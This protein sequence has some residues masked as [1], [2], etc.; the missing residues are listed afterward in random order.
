MDPKKSLKTNMSRDPDA[1]FN[2]R[3]ICRP[4]LKTAMP[5]IMN[6]MLAGER[7]NQNYRQGGDYS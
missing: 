1:F 5:H 2:L 4:L 7:M 3:P 6:N